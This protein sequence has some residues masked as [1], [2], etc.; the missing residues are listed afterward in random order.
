M[1]VLGLKGMRLEKSALST[2]QA[3]TQLRGDLDRFRSDFQTLGVHLANARTRYEEADKR[4]EKFSGRLELLTEEKPVELPEA[5]SKE[6]GD[7]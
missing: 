3:L 1:I 5:S 2:L 6:K 7:S 4:L